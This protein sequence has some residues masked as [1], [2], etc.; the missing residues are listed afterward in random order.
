MR[1]VGEAEVEEVLIDNPEIIWKKT[2]KKSGIDKKF[3]DQYYEDREQAVAYKLKNVV[4]YKEPKE[5]KE[6][7]IRSAP[8]SF[9]YVKEVYNL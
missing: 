5:L 2:Q 3:F 9:Q 8:Q 1:V 7:G 6:F 4:Q